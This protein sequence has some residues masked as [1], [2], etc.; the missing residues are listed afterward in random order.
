MSLVY[1]LAGSD[2]IPAGLSDA[3][4]T[5]RAKELSKEDPV[6]SIPRFLDALHVHKEVFC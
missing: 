3:Y 4:V 6:T 5:D 2:G 1:H